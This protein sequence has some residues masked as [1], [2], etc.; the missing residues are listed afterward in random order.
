MLLLGTCLH[1]LAHYTDWGLAVVTNLTD[2][3]KRR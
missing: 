3:C 2:I 1:L